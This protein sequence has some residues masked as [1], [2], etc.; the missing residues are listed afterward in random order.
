MT[1]RLF[2]GCHRSIHAHERSLTF[3]RQDVDIAWPTHEKLGML[4]DFLFLLRHSE[5]GGHAYVEGNNQQSM[6]SDPEVR[7][8]H[9]KVRS[10]EG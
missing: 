6:S 9:K 3:P 5:S 10:F 2:N 8:L 1:C 7:K 4:P